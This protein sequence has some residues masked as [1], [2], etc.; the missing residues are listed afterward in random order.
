V[1]YDEIGNY[2]QYIQLH[3]NFIKG[4]NF[5]N[6]YKNKPLS[7]GVYK[8]DGDSV[9]ANVNTYFTKEPETQDSESHQ[10]YI[11]IQYVYSGYEKIGYDHINDMNQITEYSDKE[12][13][14]FYSGVMK[15]WI[16]IKEKEFAIFFPGEVHKPG[17][18]NTQKTCQVNKIVIKIRP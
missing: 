11:D 1:I 9:Y 6:Q 8:I 7:D 10:K 16:S 12:D 5:I 18:I 2:N 17:I 15:N 4:F 3:K 14:I 13:I